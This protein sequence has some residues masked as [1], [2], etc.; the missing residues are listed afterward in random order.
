[1]QQG[2]LPDID[3]DR[4]VHGLSPIA[5]C[6]ACVDVCPSRAL[7][8]G[9]DALR[10]DTAACDGCGVCAAACPEK[11]IDAHHRPLLG[12][13]AGE[14]VALAACAV[15]GIAPGQG[16]IACLHGLGLRHLIALW[17][18]GVRRLLV[19]AV[20]CT[21]CPRAAVPRLDEAVAALN[22]LLADRGQSTLDLRCLPA[23]E[24]RAAAQRLAVGAGGPEPGRRRLLQRV[25]T[26]AGAGGLAC[27]QE[28]GLGRTRE[29]AR[30]LLTAAAAG[31]PGRFAFVPRIDPQRC[32]CCA[33]CVRIC[34]HGAILLRGDGDGTAANGKMRYEIVAARCSG[35]GLCLDLCED[36]ALSLGRLQVQEVRAVP[37]RERRCPSCGVAFRTPAEAASQPDRCHICTRAGRRAKLYEVRT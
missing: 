3:G 30:P 2:V 20:D 27:E 9:T 19:A 36:A 5:R 11:A 1:M 7:L 21:A 10:L 6:R 8:L 18:R 13:L 22:L 4:C 25:L 31:S 14:A 24:W 29:D 17:E 33:A 35:C 15:A 32:S 34:P 26:A 12:R 37:L 16:P 23:E 28:A